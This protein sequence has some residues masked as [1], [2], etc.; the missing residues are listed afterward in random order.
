MGQATGDDQLKRGEKNWLK[1]HKQQYL[2]VF[3]SRFQMIIHVCEAYDLLW[4]N[5]TCTILHPL[6][7]YR[8]TEYSTRQNVWQV[9]CKHVRSVKTNLNTQHDPVKIISILFVPL[10]SVKTFSEKLSKKIYIQLRQLPCMNE[11]I[12]SSHV[13]TN[14]EI[15]LW[16]SDNKI[17]IKRTQ[18]CLLKHVIG[19]EGQGIPRIP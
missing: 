17:T 2:S 4:Q 13:H 19:R 5:F 16:D 10:I 9:P 12:N 8:W 6:A 11:Q 18:S 3:L 1:S 15:R 14:Y 7:K